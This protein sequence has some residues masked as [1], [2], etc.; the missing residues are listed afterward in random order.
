FSRIDKSKNMIS[1]MTPWYAIYTKSRFEKKV[2]GRLIEKDIEAYL[3]LHKELKIWSDRKKWVEEPLIRSY[4]FVRIE[5]KDHLKVLKTPGVIKFVQIDGKTATIPPLQIKTLQ[6]VLEGK[7]DLEIT[8]KNFKPG[9]PVVITEGN[10]K[11]IAGEL[12][13]YN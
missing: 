8:D 2:F 1:E 3:P 11:G 7:A 13:T 6:R 9:D 4:V 12:V 10:L 5:D